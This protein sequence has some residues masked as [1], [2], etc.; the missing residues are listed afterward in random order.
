MCVL[1]S[2]SYFYSGHPQSAIPFSVHVRASIYLRM[3]TY[4]SSHMCNNICT[5]LIHSDDVEVQ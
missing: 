2:L 4:S 5:G 3:C 1:V